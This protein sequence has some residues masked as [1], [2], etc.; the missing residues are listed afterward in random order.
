M[1]DDLSTEA[2]PRLEVVS[3]EAGY[4][5]VPIVTG[6]CLQVMPGEIV[7]IVGP[8]G[9]GKSTLLKAVVGIL[10]LSAGEVRLAGK[11]IDH[12]PTQQ[13]ARVGMGYVPQADDVFAP[14]SVRE[15][16][17]L[18]GYLRSRRELQPRID[19]VY[20]L[21]P[22]LRKLDGRVAGRLS[23]GERKMLAIAR[24]LMAEPG[25][26][27]LDEPTANLSPELSDRVL[28][29]HVKGLAQHN[30]AILLVEQRARRAMAI[31]DRTYVL[32]AGSVQLTGSP[33]ELL[34]RPD[35][36]DLMLGQV[37]S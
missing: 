11:R 34:A 37:A 25:V 13:R 6:V 14:L 2:G 29:D 24:A 17:L 4:G 8:N 22:A 1:P 5:A 15:N 33:D 20:E 19:Y 10:R 30:V 3:A 35:F 28:E 16:L 9:A 36:G 26:L 23:G 21:F 31:S 7:T 12:L 32:V 27:I 18:G